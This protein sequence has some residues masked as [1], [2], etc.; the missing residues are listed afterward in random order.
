MISISYGKRSFY[1]QD[2]N[3]QQFTRRK[4]FYS[5]LR[6]TSNYS[7]NIWQRIKV[8]YVIILLTSAATASEMSGTKGVPAALSNNVQ[9]SFEDKRGKVFELTSR[10][11][12]KSITDGSAWLIEFYAPWCGHCQ[13]LEPTY[14][15]VAKTLH[16]NLPTQESDNKQGEPKRS[17]A[18]KNPRIVKVAKIDGN[19]ERALAS[20][21][22]IRGYPTIVLVEGWDV[23]EYSGTRTVESFVDFALKSYQEVDPIPFYSSPFGPIGQTKSFVMRLGVWLIETYQYYE[24]KGYS[25]VVIGGMFFMGMIFTSF[26]MVICIGLCMIPGHKHKYD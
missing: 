23:R 24:Q 7:K 16:E 6:G 14:E 22:N 26:F 17:S 3:D 13:R 5:G 18:T 19:A 11:F 15:A 25:K 4:L 20:R 21:F 1:E 9:S 8:G 2:V 10:N 12:D